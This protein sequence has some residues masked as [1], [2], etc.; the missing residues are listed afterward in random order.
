MTRTDSSP[1]TLQT[2]VHTMRAAII[3]APGRVEIRDVSL[4]QP[5]PDQVRI[6]IEGC[7]VCASN[8]PP[9]EGRPWFTYPMAPGVPGHEAWGWVDAVGTEVSQFRVG[10][11]VAFLSDH[12]YA[13]YDIAGEGHIVSLPDA[14][15]GEPFPAEP[16]GCAMNIHQR[17]G[18]RPGDTV[19]IVGIGFLGALLTRLAANAQARV[20]A[21]ARRPFAQRIARHMGA[22]DVIPMDDHHAIIDRVRHLT[23]MRLCDIAIECVGK[24]WP[25]DLA[26]EL[27]RERGRMIIAGYHQDGLRQCNLQLWNWRGLDIV[28]AHE[29]DPMIY[30]QGMRAAV[31][32]VVTGQLNPRALYTHRF[33]LDELGQAME[34]TRERPDAFMKA[35]IMM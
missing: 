21:I 26:A 27:V 5:R 8:I 9:W 15:D 22:T 33:P 34:M 16:L 17:C 32:A 12:A 23:N 2:P 24:Q 30:L 7:G 20:I 4:P 25:L 10:Q 29:R 19:A 6:R 3:Q 1:P 28:N 13:Q 18:I 31:D 14:L 11:R 35:M